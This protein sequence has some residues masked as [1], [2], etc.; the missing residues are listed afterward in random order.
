VT[1]ENH[2]TRELFHINHPIGGVRW[3]PTRDQIAFRTYAGLYI[4]DAQTGLFHEFVQGIGTVREIIWSPDGNFIAADLQLIMGNVNGVVI[5]DIRTGGV[6]IYGDDHPGYIRSQPQ[7][8]S[9]RHRVVFS[10][11]QAPGRADLMMLSPCIS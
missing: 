5:T 3:S 2:Q 4:A 9:D 1:E 11:S 8:S 6:Y 7:W 10:A